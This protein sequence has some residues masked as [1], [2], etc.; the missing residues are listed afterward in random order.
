V[1]VCIYACMHACMYACMHVCMYRRS[2]PYRAAMSLKKWGGRESRKEID[3][4]RAKE[5]RDERAMAQGSKPCSFQIHYSACCRRLAMWFITISC[6]WH[7]VQQALSGQCGVRMLFSRG[8]WAGL[9]Y[10]NSIRVS[11]IVCPDGYYC[12][13]TVKQAFRAAA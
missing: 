2:A 1:C 9:L 13:H 11:Q 4:E 3:R 10:F 6:C 12:R 5:R 7:T 8:G